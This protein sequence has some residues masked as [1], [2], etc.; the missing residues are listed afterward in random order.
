M[1]TEGEETTHQGTR[2]T[3]GTRRKRRRQRR[4]VRSEWKTQAQKGSWPT[5]ATG[6]RL[7]AEGGFKAQAGTSVGD[8][9]QE[10]SVTS[11]P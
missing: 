3:H 7:S 8:G 10:E 5:P 9:T 4:K 11:R 6:G 1:H 2:G